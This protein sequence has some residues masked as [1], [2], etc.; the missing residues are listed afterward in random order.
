MSVFTKLKEECEWAINQIDE[1]N[2]VSVP[3]TRSFFS[4]VLETLMRM[5]RLNDKLVEQMD[6][7]IAE[8]IKRQGG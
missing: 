5:D 6:T 4:L 2:A 7:S 3:E 8:Q 1:G